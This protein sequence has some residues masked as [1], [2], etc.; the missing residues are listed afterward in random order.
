[1]GEL[2]ILSIFLLIVEIH[3]LLEEYRLLV[4]LPEENV[5]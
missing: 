4:V 3:R 1:M 2:Y 5:P